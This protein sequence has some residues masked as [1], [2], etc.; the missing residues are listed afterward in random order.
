MR[1]REKWNRP[2]TYVCLCWFYFLRQCALIVRHLLRRCD[3]MHHPQPAVVALLW[4]AL[5]CVAY[6]D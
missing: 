2:Q 6:E 5:V 1:R 4:F 3:M